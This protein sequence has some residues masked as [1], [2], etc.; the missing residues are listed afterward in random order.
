MRPGRAQT[1]AGRRSPAAIAK[2]RGRA[3]ARSD[4]VERDVHGQII[5]RLERH[6][7]T[8]EVHGQ[9]PP[10]GAGL[11]PRSSIAGRAELDSSGLERQ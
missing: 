3:L 9:R 7:E 2:A 11:N 6:A 4:R 5:E 8:G 1:L 10:A